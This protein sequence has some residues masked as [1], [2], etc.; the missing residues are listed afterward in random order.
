MPQWTGGDFREVGAHAERI[1][2]ALENCNLQLESG[3]QYQTG[4]R[5]GTVPL[6]DKN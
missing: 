4:V 5:A 2:A 3:R 6:S 1:K